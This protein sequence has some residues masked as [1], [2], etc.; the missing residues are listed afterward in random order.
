MVTFWPPAVI[1][2]KP[3]ADVLLTVPA[4]PPGSGPLRALDP[5]PLPEPLLAVD[6]PLLA[7][8]EPLPVVALTTPYEPP[9]IAM[10]ATP[11]TM[12]LMSF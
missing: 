4:D 3:D 12:D 2:V 1:S 8:Y 10:T 6:E 11:A 7:V 9:P 5:E